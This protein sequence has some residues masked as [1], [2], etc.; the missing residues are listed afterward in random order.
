MEYLGL[1]GKAPRVLG[2]SAVILFATI[3]TCLALPL[4]AGQNGQEQPA[5]APAA[6]ESQAPEPAYRPLPSKLTLDAGTLVRVRVSDLLSSDKSKVGEA[7]SAELD[8]PLVVDGWVVARRGQTVV[9]RVAVAKKAG[10]IKGTS[11][12]GVR[13]TQLVLVDGQQIPVHTQLIEGNGSTSRGRDA[14]VVG[15]GAGV[16]TVIGGAAHGGEGAGI[17]AA[18]GAGAGL[19]GVLLTR[20]HPTVIPP[21]ST[22]TFQLQIPVTISTAH[23]GPAFRPVQPGDYGSGR[24]QRRSQPY[25]PRYRRGPSLYYSDYGA[26]D[27]WYSPWGWGPGP[28]FVGFYGWGGHFGHRG[29]HFRH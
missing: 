23:S 5:P 3:L 24:L 22:L 25:P 27:P 6:D 9:G 8:Q 1:T 29:G 26:W 10:R 21:E 14:Q 2:P 17:G 4:W 12:L 16:G 20:G 28:F 19:A 18:I 13:L 7:F 15:T 11:Q